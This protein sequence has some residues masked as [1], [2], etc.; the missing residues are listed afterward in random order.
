MNIYECKY[1]VAS[2]CVEGVNLLGTAEEYDLLQEAKACGLKHKLVD[3]LA[4]RFEAVPGRVWI[5]AESAKEAA[6]GCHL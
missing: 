5:Y 3:E 2:D 1:D 4:E 6:D